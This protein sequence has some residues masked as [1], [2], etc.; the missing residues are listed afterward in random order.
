MGKLWVFGDSNSA[1]YTDTT[2]MLQDWVK[3]YVNYLGYEPKHF[4]QALAEKLNLELKN[5]GMGGSDNYTIFET[6]F[7]QI[8][9]F[10]KED[11]VIFIGVTDASRF[12]VAITT[13]DACYFRSITA[14]GHNDDLPISKDTIHEILANRMNPLFSKEF[15]NYINLI[16]MALN[17]YKIYFWTAFDPL[18]EAK[19]V[20]NLMKL[21][22]LYKMGNITN[23][24]QETNGQINDGHFGEKGNLLLSELFYKFINETRVPYIRDI[25]NETR[26]IKFV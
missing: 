9:N 21:G 16:K 20:I 12:R 26:I 19:G 8:K 13:P 5:Y 15:E 2:M 24:A 18:R 14:G 23:I 6:M 25:Y 17:G 1:L 7:Y 22:Y 4:S 10:N 3:P 11:D